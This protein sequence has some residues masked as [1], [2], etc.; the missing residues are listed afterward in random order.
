[1]TWMYPKSPRDQT[2]NSNFA[3]QLAKV[4]AEWF[5]VDYHDGECVIPRHRENGGIP[6]VHG[7]NI[8]S[9]TTDHRLCF[10]ECQNA[11]NKYMVG[12][13]FDD[14]NKICYTHSR[15]LVVGGNG[16]AN[17]K[18]MIFLTV[19]EEIGDC[20]TYSG[21]KITRVDAP[22]FGT[23]ATKFA[24]YIKDYGH[25]YA[26]ARQCLDKCL[27]DY[28]LMTTS[29]QLITGC[30]FTKVQRTT[31]VETFCKGITL[32]ADELKGGTL[33]TPHLLQVCWKIHPDNDMATFPE[34]Q[35]GGRQGRSGRKQKLGKRK[36]KRRKENRKRKKRGRKENRKRKKKGRKKN[37][38]G[39]RG[40]KGIKR[41][42]KTGRGERKGRRKE[43]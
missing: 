28:N 17:F 15:N 14:I 31:E 30:G 40:R 3:G 5:D 11:R 38:K 9:K 4:Q 24:S 7:K 36:K 6:P 19:S 1:M 39:T 43:K 21:E 26:E 20:A 33:S 35:T 37:R 29:D 42:E 2:Q 16:K 32:P 27:E 13:E 23:K 22:N 25:D 18:C 12:C 8:L 41:K 34:R 10:I